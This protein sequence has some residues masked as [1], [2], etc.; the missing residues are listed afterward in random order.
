[1]HIELVKVLLP[2]VR[3]RTREGDYPT[4]PALPTEQLEDMVL[5]LAHY[6]GLSE[7]SSHGLKDAADPARE[8]GG[9]A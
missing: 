7:G 4:T 6:A 2:Q 9:G 8:P 1:M 3:Q 5:T